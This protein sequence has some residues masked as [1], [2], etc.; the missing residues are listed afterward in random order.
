M[1]KISGMPAAIVGKNRG[2]RLLDEVRKMVEEMRKI[3]TP[4]GKISSVD[5]GPLHDSR[6]HS[7]A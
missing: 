7:R 4:T 2:D 6:L 5:G 3:P 1:E